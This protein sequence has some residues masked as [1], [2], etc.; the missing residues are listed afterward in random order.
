MYRGSESTFNGKVVKR[1]FSRDQF[2]KSTEKRV[3]AMFKYNRNFVV[4]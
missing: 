3:D 4:N 1:R 2:Y